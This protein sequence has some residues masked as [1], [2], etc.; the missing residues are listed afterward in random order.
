MIITASPDGSF[1]LQTGGITLL[2]EGSE[3]E[4]SRM[5][6]DIYLRMARTEV[7]TPEAGFTIIG[8]GE[9]EIRGVEIRGIAPFTYCIKAEDMRLVLLSS[10]TIATLD[11]LTNID[12]ALVPASILQET[13]EDGKGI[14]R[15]LRQLEPRMIIAAPTVAIK[16]SKELGITRTE[17]EKITIK[18]RDIPSTGMTLTCLT[19]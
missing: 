15:F 17:A 18:R 13:T 8:P 5:K 9:Y 3:P 11:D 4:K 7:E 10:A 2:T 1:K 6:P 16:I 12:I 14:G 19:A